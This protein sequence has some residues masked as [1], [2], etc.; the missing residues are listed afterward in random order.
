[1]EK[2]KS[3]NSGNNNSFPTVIDIRRLI[4]KFFLSTSFNLII[5]LDALSI[6]C[7]FMSKYCFILTQH[8]GEI[9]FV[10]LY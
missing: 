8:K 7:I 3:Y 5:C 1:M 6:Y 4:L 10:V 9:N 2:G